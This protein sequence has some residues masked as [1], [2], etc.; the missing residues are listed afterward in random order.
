MLANAVAG[1]YAVATGFGML[2]CCELGQWL[3][4]GR[5]S[6]GH[7]TA[8]QGALQGAVAALNDVAD[9]ATER[10]VAAQVHP[11]GIIFA[12]LALV[13]WATVGL[14]GAGTAEG[15]MI[16]RIPIVVY[17]AMLS[18]ILYVIAELELPRAGTI[19]IEAFDQAL[20]EVRHSMGQGAAE[21]ML[22]HP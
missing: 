21:Q 9:V 6:L 12:M 3:G 19:R 2:V 1:I 5:I 17:A 14:L 8:S 16:G 7:S 4:R 18:L 11:P 20:E 15:A 10:A 22:T 13:A